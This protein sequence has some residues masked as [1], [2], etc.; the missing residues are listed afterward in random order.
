MIIELLR[1]DNSRPAVNFKLAAFPNEWRKGSIRASG[2]TERMERY[3]S[4]FQVLIDRLRDEENFTA[5]RKVQPRNWYDFASGHG[6][7]RYSANFK[8]HRMAGVSLYIDVGEEVRNKKA[9][10]SLMAERE[11]IESNLN[12]PLEWSRLDHRR[13]SRIDAARPGSIDDDDETLG[14]VREW[15]IEILLAFKRVFGPHL[16]ALDI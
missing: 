13:A 11:T 9:F 2:T 15:M 4:F 16:V 5:S 12:E 8:Q 1:I 10:D 7:I 3:R 14:E 6:G